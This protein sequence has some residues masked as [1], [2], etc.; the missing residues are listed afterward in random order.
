MILILQK[1]CK[2]IKKKGLYENNSFKRKFIENPA[3]HQFLSLLKVQLVY[4]LD[5]LLMFGWIRIM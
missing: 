1:I 4:L 2:V 5:V 3:E